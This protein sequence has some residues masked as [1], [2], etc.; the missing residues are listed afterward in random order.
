MVF[1]WLLFSEI[2]VGVWRAKPPRGSLAWDFAGI[3]ALL[4]GFIAVGDDVILGAVAGWIHSS[5]ALMMVQRVFPAFAFSYSLLRSF[6][7]CS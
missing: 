2:Y 5:V 3:T 4:L 7:V 1:N 6:E